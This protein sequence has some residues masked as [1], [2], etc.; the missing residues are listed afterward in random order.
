MRGL[1]VKEV[2]EW[3]NCTREEAIKLI[4]EVNDYEDEATLEE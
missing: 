4:Q 2:M 3:A 1:T